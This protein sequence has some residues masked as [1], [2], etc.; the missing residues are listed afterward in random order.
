MFVKTPTRR[1]LVK[2]RRYYISAHFGRLLKCVGGLQVL[3][4]NNVDVANFR[5]ADTSNARDIPAFTNA[6]ST[7]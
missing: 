2:L 5:R 1:K 7:R 4:E 3:G 6:G